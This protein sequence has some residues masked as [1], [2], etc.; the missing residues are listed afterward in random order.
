VQLLLEH[1]ADPNA[2]AKSSVTPLHQVRRRVRGRVKDR[3]R[4]RVR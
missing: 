2:V 1:R 4:V 3:D